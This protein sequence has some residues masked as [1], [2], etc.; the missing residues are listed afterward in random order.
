MVLQDILAF[1]C[2][3]GAQRY[4]SSHYDDGHLLFRT[5]GWQLSASTDSKRQTSRAWN[6]WSVNKQCSKIRRLRPTEQTVQSWDTNP[7]RT[8]SD[9]T[10]SPLL[11]MLQ[12]GPWSSPPS[13][14]LLLVV[15]TG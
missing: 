12:S 15:L 9:P 3:Q 14:C 6:Y 5:V 10:P 2:Q 4:H 8:Q 1:N 7:A 13:T 11:P